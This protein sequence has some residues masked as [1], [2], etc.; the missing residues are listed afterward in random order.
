MSYLDRFAENASERITIPNPLVLTGQLSATGLQSD[1]G[2]TAFYVDSVTGK[3]H[4]DGLSA[5]TPVQSITRALALCTAN[6]GDA[7]HCMPGHI[8]TVSAAAGLVLDKAG[9][10]I[11]F[12]GLGTNRAQIKYTTAVGADMDVSAAN[13][14]L[15]NPRFVCAKDAL[16]G[17]IDVNAANF[18]IYGG[19]WE[20]GTDFNTID[21]IVADANAD[22]LYIDGFRFIDGNAGGTQKQSFIQVAAATRPTLKRIVCT[23]DFGTGIIENGTA[24]IDAYLEDCVLDNASASPTVGILLQATSSGQARNCNIRVASGST[25]VTANNDM[26]WFECFGT[27]TDATAGERIGTLIAG[28]IETKVDT[29]ASDLILVDTVVDTIKSDLIVADALIDTIKSD[30]IVLDAIGDTIKSDLIVLDALVDAEVLKTAT[31]KSD[32]IVLDAIGDTIKSDLIVT[33]A[34]VDTIASDLIVL[35]AIGDLIK[36]AADSILSDLTT[37]R[38]KYASDVP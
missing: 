20:D 18:Q 29:I 23:G 9:V 34:I 16:T 32:L 2:G 4:N 26:Q 6:N 30:L 21:C 38:T 25:Y 27:G 33:N 17:P 24:W 15:I 10:K 11:Y 13:V 14:A 8:E 22:E 28:D 5:L 3:S 35:D 1:P 7:I 31:I 12:H 19:T 36:I 37:F